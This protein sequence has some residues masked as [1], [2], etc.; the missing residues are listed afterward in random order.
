MFDLNSDPDVIRYTGDRAFASVEEARAFLENYDPYSKEGYG[1][2]L[3][4]LRETG[5]PLGWCGLRYQPDYLAP[6]IGYRFFRKHW[7]KGY[8]TESAVACM[9][10]GFGPLTI[11]VIVGRAMAANLASIRVFEKLGLE[12]WKDDDF[13]GWPSV[14]YRLERETYLLKKAMPSADRT[15]G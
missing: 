15:T 10:Y 4:V 2:W 7:G 1:R 8:A 12:F 14:L 9:E 5:E 11:P 6:D 3:V 13:E